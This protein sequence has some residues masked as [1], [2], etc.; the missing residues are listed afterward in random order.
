MRSMSII[1]VGHRTVGRENNARKI[2]M[3]EVGATVVVVDDDSGAIPT[4]VIPNRLNVHNVILNGEVV[5]QHALVNT[6]DKGDTTQHLNDV[7]Y[8]GPIDFKDVVVAI[9]RHH[10]YSRSDMTDLFENL[11]PIS[12]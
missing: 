2:R 9:R 4:Q 6:F 1:C 8:F 10:P 11:I 12:V 3:V 5:V 7:E